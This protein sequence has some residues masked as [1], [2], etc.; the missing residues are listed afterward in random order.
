[1]WPTLRI[2]KWNISQYSLSKY[3][4]IFLTM[5][6]SPGDKLVQ[7]KEVKILQRK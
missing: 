2:A 3:K 4:L 5:Y 6:A 7:L 1:M